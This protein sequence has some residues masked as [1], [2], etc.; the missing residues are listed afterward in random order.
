MTSKNRVKSNYEDIANFSYLVFLLKIKI[1][2]YLNSEVLSLFNNTKIPSYVTPE[3]K[4][5]S[6]LLFKQIHHYPFD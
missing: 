2:S 4:Q 6:N 5:N 3:L 1:A